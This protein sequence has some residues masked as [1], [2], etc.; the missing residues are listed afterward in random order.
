MAV[1]RNHGIGHRLA[2]LASRQGGVVSLAQLQ[3]L[4]LSSAAVLGRARHGS[5]HRVHRGVYA[6]GHRAIDWETELR[7]ALLACGDGAVIS[8]GTAAALWGLSERAPVLVELTVPVEAGRKL[9]GIRCRRCRYPAPE[10]IGEERGVL[11]TTPA[12]T[13]VDQAGRL[14]LAS[15]RRLVEQAAILDLLDLTEC[16]QAIAAAKGRRGRRRLAAILAE[17]RS[18]DDAVPDVRSRLEARTLSRLLALGLPRPLVNQPI[19]LG[20]RTVIADFLWPEERLIVETDGRHTHET[21]AAF[22]RD[23][24][25]DQELLAIGYRTIRITWLQM[26]DEADAVMARIAAALAS[27]SPPSTRVVP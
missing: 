8:H 3:G 11:C 5:L 26:R 24:L 2:D 20:D 15:L 9:E 13:M 10:E 1:E 4:G 22:Q 17:W 25:R 23:R 21:A 16:D 27:G 7:A 18:E 19:S 12:R 6:V 14:G